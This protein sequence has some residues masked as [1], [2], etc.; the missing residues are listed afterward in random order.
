MFYHRGKIRNV[1]LINIVKSLNCTRFSQSLRFTSTFQENSES[2]NEETSYAKK[3]ISYVKTPEEIKTEI[4]ILV[5]GDFK[6][7]QGL[8]KPLISG[9]RV[10]SRNFEYTSIKN[11]NGLLKDNQVKKVIS[12][13]NTSLQ[14]GNRLSLLEFQNLFIQLLPFTWYAYKLLKFYEKEINLNMINSKVLILMMKVSY[15][16]FDFKLFDKIFQIFQTKNDKIPVDIL[17]WAIQVYLKTGNILIARQLFNQQVMTESELPN[18]VLN[19]FIS[20]LYNQTKNI[21]LCLTSYKLWIS[22][23]FNTNISIDSFMYNLLLDSGTSDDI[24]W[25]EKSL[26]ERGLMDK[27]AIKFGTLCNNLSKNVKSYQDFI[28][29]DDLQK[30]KELAAKDNE[31]SLLSNNL[32]YLH[33]RH[34]NYKLALDTFKSVKDRKDFQL[35]IYSIIRHFEKEEKPEVIFKILRNLRNDSNFVIHW[36]HILV[37]WRSLIKKYPHLGFKIHANFRKALKKSKYH[38]FAFLSKML[39]INKQ[40]SLSESRYYPIVKYDNLGSDLKLLPALPSLKNIESRL[41]LGILPNCELLRKSI[42]FTNDKNEFN[43][44]VEIANELNFKNSSETKNVSLN[45]EIFYKERSFGTDLSKKKF[46]NKQLDLIKK[47]KFA[48]N[49]ALNALFK[50]CTKSSLYEESLTIF[51]LFDEYNFKIVGNQESLKFL[52]MFIKWCWRNKKFK[53]LIIILDWLETQNEIK[54]DRYFWYNLRNEAYINLSKLEAEISNS[55]EHCLT[56]EELL[57]KQNEKKY[58]EKVLPKIISYY[59]LTLKR[60]KNKNEIENQKIVS[61]SNAC[62]QELIEWVDQ[63]TEVLIYGDLK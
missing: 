12:L 32:T 56:Q 63:D 60:I 7:F 31:L 33:L 35:S 53:N 10:I 41:L 61:K 25:M 24:E 5:Q 23:N 28:K 45:I 37:Y 6:N 42:R 2:I 9:Q 58:I 16:T 34:K 59:D 22:K 40:S 44:L 11:L 18:T 4:D 39:L 20:N 21:D 47:T 38:R 43:R 1:N 54:N 13:V 19:L 29:S 49:E 26:I 46:V 14:Q 3:V 30:F 36:T 55:G 51:K 17:M 57:K 27:F 15:S 52:S 8:T 62:F 50:I 48:D